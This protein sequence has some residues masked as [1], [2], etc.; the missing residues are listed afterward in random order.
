MFYE[1]RIDGPNC[2]RGCCGYTNTS[3]EGPDLEVLYRDAVKA[4]SD[5]ARPTYSPRLVF[6][7]PSIDVEMRDCQARMREEE[8]QREEQER[9]QALRKKQLEAKRSARESLERERPDLTPEAYARRL[10]E[11]EAMP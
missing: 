7:L 10:A 11:V 5:C 2:N 8:K 4:A 9:L 6:E 1:I 3:V